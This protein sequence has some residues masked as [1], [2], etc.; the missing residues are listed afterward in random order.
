MKDKIFLDTN[1]LIYLVNEDSPF[2]H[3]VVE[4]YKNLIDSYQLWISRQV[5]REYAVVMSRA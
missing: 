1:I 4:K 3:S 5:L 2:Y